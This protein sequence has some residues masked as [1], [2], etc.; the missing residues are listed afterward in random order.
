MKLSNNLLIIESGDKKNTPVIFLHGFP[1]DHY[2]W[3]NQIKHLE[4]EYYCVSYDIKGLGESDPGDG[5]YTIESFVDDLFFVMD[6]MNIDRP[7]VC[8]MSMGGYIA[9]R[10]VEREQSRFRGVIL[11]D[12]KSAADNDEAKLKR[13]AGI[14]KINSEGAEKYV[15]GFIPNLFVP[16]SVKDD[17]ELYTSV[18]KRSIK[19]DP[20][21][22][23]G[24]LLAMQGR[25]DTTP[26]MEKITLPA[27]LLCG[28]IDTITPP[29]VMREMHEKIKN[30]EFAVAPRAGHMSPIENPEFINDMILGFLKRRI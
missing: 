6:E 11:C 14:K 30:S 12:T 4:K 2:M 27:L 28:A 24:C 23:K 22:L 25:T 10:A 26:F 7:V 1:L 16:E 8:G 9:L 18:L 15:S 19:S 3:D 20:I 17:N 5:Q 13:A 29:L 21:G